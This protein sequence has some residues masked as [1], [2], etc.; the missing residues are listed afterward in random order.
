MNNVQLTK[1]LNKIDLKEIQHH[2][3]NV[4]L[5]FFT[6]VFNYELTYKNYWLS[7]NFNVN[8]VFSTDCFELEDL[9]ILDYCLYD[10]DNDL[11]LTH[12]QEIRL[13]NTLK[14]LINDF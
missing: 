11:P 10:E 12:E 9:S 3:Q 8:G 5:G 7:I 1:I 14:Q 6:E 13:E 4:Q 2:W